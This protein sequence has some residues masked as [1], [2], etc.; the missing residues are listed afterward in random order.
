[1]LLV[2]EGSRRFRCRGRCKLQV[3]GPEGSS[4][5]RK[6]AGVRSEGYARFRKVPVQGQVQA[7][8]PSFPFL[9]GTRGTCGTWLGLVACLS[10]NLS[11]NL[12]SLILRPPFLVF[13]L[14]PFLSN[15]NFCFY[16]LE[17]VDL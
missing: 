9:R 10:R 3:Q 15:F 2:P 5:F 16:L 12:F 8:G 4:E 14:F 11:Q 13:F 17:D 7:A 6:V 1:M